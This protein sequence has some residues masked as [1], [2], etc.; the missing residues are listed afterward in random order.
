MRVAAKKLRYAAEFFAPQDHGKRNRAYRKALSRLQDALGHWHD[1]VTATRLA[2]GLARQVRRGDDRRRAR[3]GRCAGGGARARD[4]TRMATLRRDRP[5]L[6]AQVTADGGAAAA[7]ALSRAPLARGRS[8]A[9]DLARVRA[10]ADGPLPPRARRHPRRRFLGLRLARR[11]TAAPRSPL[12]VLFHGLEGSSRSHYAR[13]LMRRAR[14]SSAGAAS[15]RIFAA[16]AASRTCVRART[17]PAITRRSARCSRPFA[18]APGRTPSSTPR[19][20]RSAA[21][22]SSTGSGA[23]AATRRTC[24]RR[25]PPCRRRSTSPPPAS[26]STAASTG[27][28]RG[29]SSRRCRPKSREIARRFPDVLDEGRVARR[30]LDV[31]IRRR[32]HGAAARL[33]G[34]ARLLASRVQQ[35]MARASGAPDARAEREERSVRAARVAAR[36]AAR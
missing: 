31:R 2:A 19:A 32:G 9:D 24:W 13:A 15:S 25:L 23:P 3:L 8:R 28:T 30:L 6:D 12:V 16:A 29:T 26:T 7:A 4:R 36:P 20:S 22:R 5:F 17:T 34:H 33:R 35:A 27:S 1:A 18:R 21:A 14:A 10:A 11:R